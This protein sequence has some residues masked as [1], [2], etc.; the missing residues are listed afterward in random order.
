M[1]RMKIVISA[2]GIGLIVQFAQADWRPVKRLTWTSAS[3]AYPAIAADAAGNLHL[4]WAESS[5]GI[6]VMYYKKSTDGG[7]TWS[8]RQRLNWTAADSR[9][10]DI[11]VDNSGNPHVVWIEFRTPGGFEI[12]YKKSPD[13]GATWPA[14]R[15]LSWTPGESSWPDIGVDYSGNPFVVWNDYEGYNSDIYYRASTDGGSNWQPKK[16]ISWTT[17]YSIAPALPADLNGDRHVVWW[18]DTPGN[19]EIYYRRKNAW[20]STWLPVKRLT[21]TLGYSYYPAVAVDSSG[22]VYVVWWDNTSGNFEI[23]YKKSPNP[24]SF[25]TSLKRLTWTGG[26]SGDP[27]IVIDSSDNLHV[28]WYDQ[29]P[30]NSEIYYKM[31]L[32][33]G[34]SWTPSKRLT[35]NSGSS[36]QPGAAVDPSDNIHVVWADDTPGNYEI[37]Y[38]KYAK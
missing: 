37:Y 6:G 29:T 13:G 36:F 16:R 20:E 5:P 4:V 14:S 1:G 32:N 12:F 21:W 24:G 8:P 18:D 30:G 19:N 26:Q 35:W 17:G 11:A 7:S 31:S 34:I 23:Y 25:W 38:R 15:R 28:F 2:I 9:Y 27:I 22:S 10:P 33:G 3:S